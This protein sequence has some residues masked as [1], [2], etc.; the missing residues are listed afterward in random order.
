MRQTYF[1]IFNSACAAILLIA[2]LST[3]AAETT[4]KQTEPAIAQRQKSIAERFNEAQSCIKMKDSACAQVALASINPASSLAKIIQGQIALLENDND[5]ALRLL[6]PLQADSKLSR[7]AAA[8]LHTTLA[9]A[10]DRSQ[11][12]QLA[13]EEY[14]LAEK[15]LSDPAITQANQNEIVRIIQALPRS[16]I[17]EM[18]GASENPTL[19]GWIDLVIAAENSPAITALSNWRNT[20]QDHPATEATITS[21]KPQQMTKQVSY[22]AIKGKLAILLPL[23]EPAF[24]APSQA[25]LA[26]IQAAQEVSAGLAIIQVYPTKGLAS[27][28]IGLYQQAIAEG[29]TKVIG[30]LT[31]E[32]VTTLAKELISV[33][34]IALNQVDTGQRKADQLIAF[35]LPIEPEAQQVAQ[36][37]RNHG[38]Q[39]TI[40]VGTDSAISQHMK[41]AF[42]EEWKLQLG[43]VALDVTITADSNL[44]E[45]K[46][47]MRQHPADM[48]FLATTAVEAHDIRPYLDSATPTFA[49]SHIYNGSPDNA[50][51]AIHFADMPWLIAPN[52]GN[53]SAFKHAG[54]AL[55]AG[56]MQRWFA[57][58]VD[59]YQLLA[60]QNEDM[61]I[62]AFFGLTGKLELVNGT[63]TRQSS[64]AQLL[65]EGVSLEQA[66]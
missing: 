33:P 62:P 34:T 22:P 53:Y 21:L 3:Y 36:Y 41:K 20:Y 19:Q 4:Q 56:D 28:I 24:A 44:S 35:G 49:L 45:I 1:P 50:L 37:A 11:N 65:N 61:A 15:L 16:T 27:E 18:R 55:P 39:S 26:G 51:L 2:S 60:R 10:Y 8:T 7:E 5:G 29:A 9:L 40:I 23:D 46:T 38:M 52:N 25:I 58:G 32:E 12:P 17:I 57:L 48:I 6:L 63:V 42:I 66:P 30:P 13:L 54:A 14:I 43:E 31:R 47:Q 59:T 64:M